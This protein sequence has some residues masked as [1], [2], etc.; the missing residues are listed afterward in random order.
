MAKT[1]K[2]Q[3]K[4]KTY[5]RKIFFYRVNAGF[6]PDTGEPR[7]V[8]FAPGLAHLQAMPYTEDGCYLADEEGKQ[9]CCWIDKASLP[10]HLKIAYIRRDLHPPVESEGMFEPLVLA[11]GGGLAELTHFILFPGGICGAEFNLYGPRASKI[12]FYFGAKLRGI[13]PPFTL[14]P[15]VRPDLN[16]RLASLTDIKLLDMKVRASYASTIQEVDEDLGGAFAATIKA[17]SA[18]PVDELELVFLRKKNKKFTPQNVSASLLNALRT[19]AGKPDLRDGVSKF[20]LTGVQNGENRVFDILSEQFI[21]DKSV[22][23]ALNASRGVD[24][25]AMFKAIQE[26]YSEVESQLASADDLE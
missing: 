1:S 25:G 2:N 7:S 13:C 17:V 20:K 4:V 14:N 26:A 8:N 5:K 12:P 9:L 23:P 10:H 21:M 18:R 6:S 24:S 15:L 11:Q 16:A 19:L 3:V 22:A